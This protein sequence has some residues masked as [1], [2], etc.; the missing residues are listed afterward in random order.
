MRARFERIFRRRTGYVTLDRLL[1]RLHER[2]A[3]LLRVLDRPEI[4]LHTNGSEND[5]RAHVTKRKISGGTR[6]EAGRVARDVLLGLMKT[7][8]KLGLSFAQGRERPL[9]NLLRQGQRAQEV[10]EVVGQ[11]VGCSRTA[12]EI[13]TSVSS[14]FARS[15]GATSPRPWC[16]R[17]GP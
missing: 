15:T 1:A 13:D 7:C 5:I 4:P 8:A 6:S 3:E 11:G 2:K 17:A 9:L 12:A 16:A 14:P 10:G